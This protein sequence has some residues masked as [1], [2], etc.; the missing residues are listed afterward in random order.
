MKFFGDMIFK[1]DY[2][3]CWLRNT[4]RLEK[5]FVELIPARCR[6]R[7]LIELNAETLT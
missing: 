1:I 6:I 5:I 3:V 4:S 2:N 7:E